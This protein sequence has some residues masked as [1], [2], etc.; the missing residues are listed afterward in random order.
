MQDTVQPPVASGGGFELTRVRQYT[1][2]F[3]NRVGKLAGLLRMLADSG[4]RL[5]ALCVEESADVALIRIIACDADAC[6]ACLEMERVTFSECD[7]LCVEVPVKERQPLLSLCSAL[8][9]AE[10]NIHYA[11]PMIRPQ[12][13][14]PAMAF[15]VEDLTLA[16]RLLMRHDFRILAESDL[17]ATGFGGTDAADDADGVNGTES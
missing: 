15:Y 5:S 10:I 3:S 4:L 9:A 11:Y 16:A 8:L 13:Q 2:C 14:R 7:V 17:K 6:A 12:D 1:I